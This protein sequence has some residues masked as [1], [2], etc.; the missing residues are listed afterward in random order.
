[1]SVSAPPALLAAVADAAPAQPTIGW[2]RRIGEA[3]SAY[4]PVLLMAL[5]AL[6][7]W[8]LVKNTPVLEA[9]P[10]AAPLRHVPDYTMTRFT[11]QRFAADGSLGTQIEGDVLRHYP[12]TDTLEID[13][14]R[15]RSIAPGGGVTLASAR[16]ALSNG[17]GSEVQL[18][19]AAR[20]LRQPAGAAP[21][22]AEVLEFRGEFL[23]AFLR[24]EQLRSHLPVV[25]TRGGTELR[26]DSLAYNQLD[27]VIELQGRVRASFAAVPPR[28]R[29]RK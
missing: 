29:A 19:G 9:T 1:V 26:G 13:N 11:V 25:V 2:L 7:T 6:G 20:V 4:L 3:A 17:D 16:Q 5:L 28:A 21:G 24:T 27:R 23:H 22:S 14:P 12:D 10:A 18:Q 8:W 15:I